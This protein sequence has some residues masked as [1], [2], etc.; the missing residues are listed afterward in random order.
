MFILQ[1][2]QEHIVKARRKVNLCLAGVFVALLAWVVFIVKD[3]VA[4]VYRASQPLVANHIVIKRHNKENNIVL[5]KQNGA[6]RV[7]EPY[8]HQASQV[9]IDALLARIQHGCRPL[10]DIPARLPEMYGEIIIDKSSYQI[11]ELNHASDEIYAQHD[12]RWL[13]CDKL[14]LSMALAPAISFIDK[15]LYTGELRAIVGDFGRLSDFK[16]VDLSV[17]EV[18]FSDAENL[19]KH[20]I[21]KLTF[22]ADDERAYHV[23]LSED[24]EHLLLFDKAKSMT[25]VIASQ[26]KLNALVGL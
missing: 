2:N 17:M 23:F 26:T 1:H 5:A 12:K 9:V 6:W 11:G 15:Q 4:R 25:Y 24:G 3:E 19:P 13:L 14:L 10:N 22:I 21:S 8:Q 16:G 20:A 18:A 7:V